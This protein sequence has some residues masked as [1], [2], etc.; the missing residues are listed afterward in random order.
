VAAAAALVCASLAV[1]STV[2]FDPQG[3][4]L[5]GREVT[6]AGLRFSTETYPS[7]KPLPFVFAVPL[8]L[9]GGAAPALWLAI[10]RSAALCGLG[11][12]YSLGRAAAGRAAGA[13]AALAVALAPG[14]IT[15]AIDG[16]S[17]P[18]V[19]ALVL[20]ALA[21]HR[22]R[23]ERLAL[24]LLV[25]AALDR[26]EALA[27]ACGYA[28]VVCGRAGGRARLGA[29]ALLAV[30]P[31]AWLGGDW[32][33]SGD[34]L[35]G[36][37]LALES[38]GP[39]AHGA[40]ALGTLAGDFARGVGAPLLAGA[41]VAVA[42]AL[43]RRD[44]RLLLLAALPLVWLAADAALLVRG[45]PRSEI[46]RFALPAV[47]AGCL[48]GAIGLA[49]S[50]A[51]AGPARARAVAL[52]AVAALLVP[53]G[54]DAVENASAGVR[55]AAWYARS[56]GS[57]GDAV[58]DAGGRRALL[59]CGHLSV[60]QWAE[61]TLAWRLGV[62]PQRLTWPGAPGIV[63][64][65]RGTRYPALRRYERRH[66][67]ATLRRIE[68]LDRWTLLYAGRPPRRCPLATHAAGHTPSVE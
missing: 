60:D 44:R 47:A 67:R 55:A 15:F 3:W 42:L 56:V 62:N 27:L 34:P 35:R 49:R 61:P 1:D 52:V 41:V 20:G 63:L 23:R 5:W 68:R 64:V 46:P 38:T 7:W 17:E 58:A 13:L 32:L 12:A 16:R 4:L 43:R 33:G 30:A 2:Q 18:I 54:S 26:P 31:L 24:L 21:A 53:F 66:A 9:T 57:L 48:L 29:A 36:A 8:S 45:Y 25:L 51:L 22:A 19:I 11:L 65:L 28:V 10:E 37:R 40:A 50:V 14:W 6:S 59:R 39:R